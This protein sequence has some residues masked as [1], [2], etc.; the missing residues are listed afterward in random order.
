M[1]IQQGAVLGIALGLAATSVAVADPTALNLV[2]SGDNYIGVQSRD[3]ILE[4]YSEKSVASIEPN[5]W[6]VLYYDPDVTFKAVDVK[7]GAG[8]EMEVTHP[9]HPV[10]MFGMP[11]KTDDIIDQSRVHVDSD[12]A[13]NIATS[14]PLLKGLTIRATKMTLDNGDIGPMW[15]VE[16]WAAKVNDPTKEAYVGSVC[17]SAEDKSVLKTDLTP[18]N[19]DSQY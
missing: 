18:R 1:K 5:I 3:K 11:A 14:Q 4:V 19:A 12:Q 15:K 9:M 6:H 13:L 16:V 8:Q 17:I 2:R 10:H 7:F